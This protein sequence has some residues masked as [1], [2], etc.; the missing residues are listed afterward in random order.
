MV[1]LQHG[2]STIDSWR[3]PEL[4]VIV[5]VQNTLPRSGV[6]TTRLEHINRAEPDAALFLI[7]PDYTVIEEKG[8]FSFTITRP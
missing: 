3:I 7:P 1:N 5:L 6:F 2:P 4:S 8:T